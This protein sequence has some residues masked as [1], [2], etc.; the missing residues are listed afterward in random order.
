MTMGK[1][2]SLWRNHLA[3]RGEHFVGR[4]Q[5]QHK[6]TSSQIIVGLRS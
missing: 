5:W 4:Y 2:P 1:V 6:N 3:C